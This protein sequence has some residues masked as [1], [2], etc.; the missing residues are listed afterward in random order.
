MKARGV[1]DR[2]AQQTTAGAEG[3]HRLAGAEPAHMVQHVVGCPGAVLEHV[4]SGANPL[5]VYLPRH[6]PER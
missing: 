2:A 3:M 5:G 6:W 4:Q 1:A